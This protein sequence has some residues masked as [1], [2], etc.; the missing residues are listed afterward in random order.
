MSQRFQ[1]ITPG[2]HLSE[3]VAEALSAEIRAG[4]PAPGEK[5]PTEAALVEQFAV[6][7]TV[8][9]EAVSR[10]KSLGVVESRQGSGV[11]VRQA[12]FAPLNFDTRSSASVQAVVQMVEVRRA[13]EAEVAAL[14][15]QRRSTD[16]LKDIRL[17]MAALDE[18]VRAGGD[19]AEE[20]VNYHRAIAG[21]AQNPFLISTLDYLRQF[22]RG[23]TRV[24]RANEA[25]RADFVRQVRD[26]HEAIT[27]AIETGDAFQARQA[28]TRHMD[29]AIARIRQA[30]P[31]FW[32]Q[33]GVQLASA[34]LPAAAP[35]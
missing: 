34:L 33:E 9:R 30:D 6:S 12:A 31:A 15:A 4:R 16:Q 26:E 3:Q 28:A 29:N 11:F 24:T 17:A 23:V 1:S 2:V 20:D 18:A 13:L 14:A 32:A 35:R 25:R 19:G 21:A 27:R 22:L 10:L 7:R 8:V 5:L